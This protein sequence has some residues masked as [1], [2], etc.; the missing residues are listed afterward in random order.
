MLGKVYRTAVH[1][2]NQKFVTSFVGLPTF[3]SVQRKFLI[4]SENNLP[5][6]DAV[7]HDCVGELLFYASEGAMNPKIQ[8]IIFLASFVQ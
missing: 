1:L 7:D 3:G 6:I 5:E 8:E 4:A 2:F